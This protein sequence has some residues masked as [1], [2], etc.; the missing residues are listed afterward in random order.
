LLLNSDQRIELNS[1]ALQKVHGDVL[2]AKQRDSA[3][4]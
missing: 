1:G 3:N 2:D 4:R